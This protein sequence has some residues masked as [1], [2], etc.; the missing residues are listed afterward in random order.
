M[1]GPLPLPGGS[2]PCHGSSH[3]S[4]HNYE[5][6]Q[7]QPGPH[8][9]ALSGSPAC[10]SIHL[11]SKPYLHQRSPLSGGSSAWA[12]VSCLPSIAVQLDVLTEHSSPSCAKAPCLLECN[13]S[14][15]CD[16]LVWLPT[17]CSSL[18]HMKVPCLPST[19]TGPNSPEKCSVPT[20]ISTIHPAAEA[21]LCKC[22]AIW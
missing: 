7:V 14:T 20:H 22:R 11:P 15:K 4:Q 3:S 6:R 5:W 8:A 9:D 1:S 17:K 16:S 13:P 2:N 19:E 10:G 21:S 12:K 18:A